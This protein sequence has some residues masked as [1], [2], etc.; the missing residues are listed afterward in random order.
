MGKEI[1]LKKELVD[2]LLSYF[3][4]LHPREGVLL[5]RGKITKD[6]I[7]VTDL[8]IPP[9]AIHGEGFASFPISMLPPDPSVLGV[10]HSHPD[11]V[12]SPSQEDILHLYGR[13]ILIVAYPYRSKDDI[14]VFNE[15]GKRIPF[16]IVEEGKT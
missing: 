12:L 15:D 8:V 9:F 7:L 1:A 13:L 14:G 10:A 3:K 6:R 5:L 2:G 16:L 4:S 11:G